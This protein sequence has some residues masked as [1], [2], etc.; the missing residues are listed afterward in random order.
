MRRTFAH[1]AVV[2]L[3]SDGDPAAPGAAITLALCGSW[4]HEPPCPLAPH[5]TGAR[6]VGAVL[7]VRIL[8]AAD[9]RRQRAVRQRI[10]KALATGA[11]RDPGGRTVR[12][13]LLHTAATGRP[14]PRERQRG[15]RLAA[16]QNGTMTTFND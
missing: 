10:A 7:R 6:R 16:S 15:R 3:P 13:K 11:L 2:A 1:N 5:H 14:T 12:W 8:F 4:D 9:P